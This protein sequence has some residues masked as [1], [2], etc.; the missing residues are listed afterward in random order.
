[1]SLVGQSI[2]VT[3]AAG[4]IA[5]HIVRACWRVGAAFARWTICQG[6]WNGRA[7]SQRTAASSSFEDQCWIPPAFPRRQRAPPPSSI[8]PPW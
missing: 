4:F 3:G 8:M 7:F 1:M 2:L 6:E 5:S